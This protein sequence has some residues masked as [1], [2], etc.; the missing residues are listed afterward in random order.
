MKLPMILLLA[1]LCSL[2]LV[3]AFRASPRANSAMPAGFLTRGG[4]VDRMGKM[5]KRHAL[6]SDMLDLLPSSFSLAELESYESSGVPLW[7]VFGSIFAVGITLTIPV[8]FRKMQ[9]KKNSRSGP[10]PEFFDKL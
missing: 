10:P 9:V 3:Q 1:A 2:Q 4:M 8:V 6:K 7:A 5:V